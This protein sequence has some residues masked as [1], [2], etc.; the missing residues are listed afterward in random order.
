MEETSFGV[1]M[2]HVQGLGGFPTVHP[3]ASGAWS[4]GWVGAAASPGNF[5]SRSPGEIPSHL[6]GLRPAELARKRKTAPDRGRFGAD[7]CRKR[8]FVARR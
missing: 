6:S 8:C 4:G 2:L 1:V 7:A 5:R 3:V